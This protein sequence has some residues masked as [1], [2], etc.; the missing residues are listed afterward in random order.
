M[1][2]YEISFREKLEQSWTKSKRF[3]TTPTG[4]ANQTSFMG[5]GGDAS[6]YVGPVDGERVFMR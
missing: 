2:T 3:A 5:A 4:P 6:V 1:L